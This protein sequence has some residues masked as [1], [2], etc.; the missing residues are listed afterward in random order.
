MGV[1]RQAAHQAAVDQRTEHVDRGT[2]R[3]GALEDRFNGLQRELLLEDGEAAKEQLLL[4]REQVVAPAD[5]PAHRA[6]ALRHVWP[7]ATKHVQAVAQARQQGRR[8]KDV[9]ARRGQLDRQR[10]AFQ[11]ATDL[12]DRGGI[13]GVDLQIGVHGARTLEEERDRPGALDARRVRV[14]RRRGFE[15]AKRKELLAADA[16]RGLARRKDRHAR[17]LHEQLLDRQVDIRD[18]LAIVEQDQHAA[19]PQRMEELIVVPGADVREKAEFLADGG[20]D[21]PAVL[22]RGELHEGHVIVV[23]VAHALGH[24][25]PKARLADASRPGDRHDAVRGIEQEPGKLPHLALAPDHA[26]QEDR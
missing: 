1:A 3:R 10:D 18:L 4:R 17:A 25:E 7:L 21:E 23:R 16:D 26:R 19:I 8:G 9:R 22:H 14:A 13:G 11:I 2:V 24:K 20:K 6:Q 15:R 12:R 5:R